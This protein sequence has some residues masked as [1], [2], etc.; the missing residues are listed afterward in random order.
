MDQRRSTSRRLCL[1]IALEAMSRPAL[2]S[3]ASC[4][5]TY[6]LSPDCHHASCPCTRE[7]AEQELVITLV[8]T[9]PSPSKSDAPQTLEGAPRLPRRSLNAS[10][11]DRALRRR[12]AFSAPAQ[13]RASQGPETGSGPQIAHSSKASRSSPCPSCARATVCANLKPASKRSLV[14]KSKAARCSHCCTPRSPTTWSS[15]STGG[16]ARATRPGTSPRCSSFS[17]GVAKSGI[18]VAMACS[19]SAWPSSCTSSVAA[20][21]LCAAATDACA[22]ARTCGA[23]NSAS[24]PL[25]APGELCCSSCRRPARAASSRCFC[26]SIADETAARRCITLS[27]PTG[28]ANKRPST[29]RDV[30]SASR[31]AS[32]DA[33]ARTGRIA[34]TDWILDA[35]PGSLRRKCNEASCCMS[36]Q[37]RP[38]FGGSWPAEWTE[39]SAETN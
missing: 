20:C 35:R 13:T 12:R 10:P 30:L 5:Q 31:P 34:N 24:T 22:R 19:H 8:C 1:C 33:S 4:R 6:H 14:A 16:S 39:R 2:K 38:S 26:E 29:P 3:A 37:M 15:A 23:S 21:R 11:S 28:R 27:P 25:G 17:S 32:I 7:A 18:I 36:F 9:S